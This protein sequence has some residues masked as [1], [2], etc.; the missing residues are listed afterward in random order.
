MSAER[1]LDLFAEEVLTTL[2]TLTGV[3]RVGI[4]TTAISTTQIGRAHV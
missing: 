1:G 2:G 4:G 3:A